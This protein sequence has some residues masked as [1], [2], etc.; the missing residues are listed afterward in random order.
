MPDWKTIETLAEIPRV[1]ARRTPE[2]TALVF[3]DRRTTFAELERRCAEAAAALSAEGVRPGARVAWLDLNSDRTYE[4]LFA[5]ARSGAV[6]CPI[7]WRLSV[8]EIRE[9]LED[10]EAEILFVGKRFFD[11]A[12]QLVLTRLRKIVAIDAVRG[13][14]E[15]YSDWRIRHGAQTAA[16]AGA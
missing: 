11:V 7:N 2:R 5:C 1:H 9:I 3:A 4:M 13:G 12:D 6:F 15:S 8:S 10:A 14:W 16:S